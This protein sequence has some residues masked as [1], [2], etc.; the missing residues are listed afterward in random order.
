MDE[1]QVV[2]AHVS[3]SKTVS[4]VTYFQGLVYWKWG[5]SG[6][7]F[8]SMYKTEMEFSYTSVTTRFSKV[9]ASLSQ[10]CISG[11]VRHDNIL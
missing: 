3:W 10:A 1:C 2:C 9:F 11:I 8:P 7:H 5:S 4:G 6:S